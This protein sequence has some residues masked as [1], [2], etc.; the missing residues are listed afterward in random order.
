MTTVAM[1]S[2]LRSNFRQHVGRFNSWNIYNVTVNCEDNEYYDF[3][4]SADSYGE[5]CTIAES[6]AQEMYND[7]VLIQIEQ[8][9]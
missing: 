7:I 9:A 6:L 4:V 2:Q 5:A 1:T 8:A 3:E